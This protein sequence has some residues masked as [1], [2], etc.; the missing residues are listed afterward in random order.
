LSIP[1]S[2][3]QGMRSLQMETPPRHLNQSNDG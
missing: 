2:I 1:V 3:K